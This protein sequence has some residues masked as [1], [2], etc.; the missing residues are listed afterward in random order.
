MKKVVF[1]LV[2]LV[3]KNVLAG[4]YLPWRLG[5]KTID[6]G[7]HIADIRFGY[8]TAKA[9]IEFKGNILY[10]QGLGDSMLN[11]DPLFETLTKNGYRVIAFDYMG[12][13]GSSGSMNDT[14]IQ[15]INNIGDQIIKLLAKKNGPAGDKYHIIGWSTGGLAAQEKA[16]LDGGKKI[17]SV[18]LIAPGIAP[19]FIV[20]EGLF[21]W[22][23]DEISLRTLTTNTFIGVNNPH[24]DPIYPTSPI[25]V[26]KFAWNL[27][28]TAIKAR[29]TWNIAKNIGGLVLLSGRKDTYVDAIKTRDT[30]E[31]RAPHYTIM[32]YPG[33]LHEIDNEVEKIAV[34]AR[35]DI[36]NFLNNQ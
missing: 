33:A 16:Y 19:N 3:A 12:Q 15:N 23:I 21:N 27:Q 2:L 26:P 30:I 5:Y 1:L 20:G 11:H 10:Y 29:M 14:T 31:K 22:P 7:E 17:L 25:N 24:H 6:S 36:L 4:S 18:V 32:S 28:A 35:L 8:L 34:K 13:G 9:G